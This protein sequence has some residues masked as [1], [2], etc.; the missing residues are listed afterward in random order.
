MFF[1]LVTLKPAYILDENLEAILDPTLEVSVKLKEKHR[2][3]KE[4]DFLHFQ[5]LSMMCIEDLHQQRNFG[6][7]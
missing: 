7:A 1:F 4:D 2:K 6:R 3:R 5:I